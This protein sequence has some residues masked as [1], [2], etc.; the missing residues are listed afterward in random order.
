MCVHACV[1]THVCTCVCINARAYK[2]YVCMC[3]HVCVRV[4]VNCQ[5]DKT[6]FRNMDLECEG[7]AY[8]HLYS[9]IITFSESF[10]TSINNYYIQLRSGYSETS[11]IRQWDLRIMLD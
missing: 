8:Y 11:L 4:C 9:I 2:C 6:I 7:D 10:V 3:V 5:E 1:Y